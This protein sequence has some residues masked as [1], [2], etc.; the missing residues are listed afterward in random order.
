MHASIRRL[1]LATIVVA[2]SVCVSARAQELSVRNLASEV[3]VTSPGS[4]AL[5]AGAQ[6]VD[7]G[8]NAKSMA[9]LPLNLYGIRVLVGGVPAGIRGASPDGIV[10]QVPTR[11]IKWG[12]VN[13]FWLRG[14][15]LIE[16]ETP[17]GRWLGWINEQ[18]VSPGIFTNPDGAAQGI[19]RCGNN[20]AIVTLSQPIENRNTRIQLIC[21]GLLAV[22]EVVV[23][24]GEDAVQGSVGRFGTFAGLDGVSFDL[25]SWVHGDVPVL[26]FAGGRVSNQIT[27][28]VQ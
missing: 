18:P 1:L 9:E 20:P 24:V 8:V 5:V 25:P 21:T 2:I 6:F 27:L 11:T 7:G 22:G 26:L 28:R 3:G 15:F 19:A 12:N 16:V 13:P 10:F 17:K 14:W 4:L 23:F